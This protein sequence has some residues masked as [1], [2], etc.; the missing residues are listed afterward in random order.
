MLDGLA[1]DAAFYRRA[2]LAGELRGY[3]R[4]EHIGWLAGVVCE[5]PP[6]LDHDYARV[7]LL[8]EPEH[9]HTCDD[10]MTLWQRSVVP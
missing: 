4:D 5:L 7:R 9:G 1:N 2:L 6:E 10:A 8:R 3:L